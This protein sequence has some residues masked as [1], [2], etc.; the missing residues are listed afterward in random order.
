MTSDSYWLFQLH[1]EADPAEHGVEHLLQGWNPYPIPAAVRRTSTCPATGPPPVDGVVVVE[2][3]HAV[4]RARRSI[5]SA[6]S[7]TA[8]RNASRVFGAAV[9][10]PPACATTSV[11][12][13]TCALY[14]DVVSDS[15][16]VQL[17]G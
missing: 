12:D 11:R 9:D 17:F 8:W 6:P 5:M 10:R 4:G 3:E 2:D 14:R 15:P 13:F 16:Q 7:A 1:V